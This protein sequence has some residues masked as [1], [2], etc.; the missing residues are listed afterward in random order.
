MVCDHFTLED[1]VE[2]IPQ[3]WYRKRNYAWPKSSNLKD[4]KKAVFKRVRP[5]E[6]DFKFNDAR[7]LASNIGQHYNKLF[8]FSVLFFTLAICKLNV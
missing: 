8:V 4:I 5:N 6:H 2:V 7:C 3:L 1:T